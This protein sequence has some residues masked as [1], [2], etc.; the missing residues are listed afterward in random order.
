M[1]RKLFLSI[2]FL[3][4]C[5]FVTGCS[6]PGKI[7]YEPLEKAAIA[8]ND[9]YRNM[10]Q[11]FPIS[12]ADS[13]KDGKGD[14][15]GIIDKLDYIE[16][17]NYNGIWLN[18]IGPSKTYHHYDV[19]D[20]CAIAKEFGTMET[21][22]KLVEECHKRGM[23]ILID[24]V[25]NHSSNNHPWF[26]ESYIAARANQT[27]DPDYLKYNW[28][29]LT[30]GQQVPNGYRKVSSNDSVAYEARFDSS[31]PDL[32]LQQVLDNGDGDLAT[33]L[34]N[35]FKFWLVDHNVDGF[36]LD[37][38]TS[39]FTGDQTKNLE[40]LTWLN[41][42]CRKLK[43]DCYI[44]GEGNWGS[45][46]NENKAYQASGVNSFFQFGNAL[47]TQGYLTGTVIQERATRIYDAL[48]NNQNNADGGIEAP[49]IDNHDTMRFPGSV[50][51]KDYSV[52]FV[53]GLLQQLKGAT[54]TYYG[55]EMGLASQGGGTGDA[56]FRLPVKWGDDY[57]CTVQ[58]T[59][60]TV[61]ETLCYPFKDVKS[62][63]KDK[64]SILNY[65]KK[66][67]LI[68]LAFPEIAK[69]DFEQVYSPDASFCVIKR[70]YEGSTIYVAINAS[71]TKNVTF[72]FTEYGEKVVAELCPTS[73]VKQNN[74]KVKVIEMPTQSIAIIK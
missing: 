8:S 19:E 17:M 31:M 49:F 60:S 34:K 59:K 41:N 6:E 26:K 45:N 51:R 9:H 67:N 54:Y 36:R 16:S 22:D 37:A 56:F 48:V 44:V 64:N 10:Y 29:R 63:L 11:I 21:F 15:Q 25:I 50:N 71:K 14:L 40:F 62:Q 1:Q 30:S 24:L 12:F 73:Y 7:S 72:D 70:T 65:V 69:G 43:P 18:P 35:I 27:K 32:N 13:N 53:L 4:L 66:A 74:K 33:E 38:V 61:D 20:Y 55:D 2:P 23:T 3:A 58:S 46:S 42:E 39:Y 28:V 5:L 52:K 57:T 68:R 47:N